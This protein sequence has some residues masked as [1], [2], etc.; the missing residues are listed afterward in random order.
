MKF[1][2]WISYLLVFIL[3]LVFLPVS[4]VNAASDGPRVYKDRGVVNAGFV[5]D[6][7]VVKFKNDHKP[8]RVI[9]V[10]EGKVKEKVQEYALRPDVVYAEPNYYAQAYAAPNDPLYKYQWN[11]ADPA[12]GGIG[13]EAA[14]GQSTGGG[15]IV[16][17]IDTGIAYES[18]GGYVQAPDLAGTAFVPGYDFVNNDNHANDDNSHGTHVAGTVAQSTNNGVGVAGIAYNAKL[19]PIKV[20]DKR[21][22]GSYA[23]IALGI[24]Y[25][26]DNGAKVINM[27]LGGPVPAQVL[28]D[29]LA[30]A[31]GLGVTI[32]AAAGNDATG[33]VGYPAA[34]D[35]YVIAVGATRLDKQL[36]YYSN[37]G[38]SLDLVAPGGD[39]NVD[40]NGDG[41]GDGILQNTFNPS[42]KRVGDFGYYF[43]QGTSM[44]SPHVAGAAALV[45][46]NGIATKPAD[47]QKV[48]QDTA[49]DLGAAGRDDRYGY[50]LVNVAAALGQP[51][52]PPVNQAP[53]ADSQ[54]VSTKVGTPV[55]ITLTASDPDDDVLLFS[56]VNG[57]TSGALSGEAPNLTYTPSVG[58]TG[59]DS[60]SFKAND[61]KLDS[62]IAVVTITVTADSAGTTLE[63]GISMTTQSKK[64]GKNTFVWAVATV[65]TG[66][67][68]AT[69]TGHWEGATTDLD[70]GTTAANG[71]VVLQSD[72]IKWTGE[73]VTFIFVVDQ[74]TK[75]GIIY[76]LTGTTQASVPYPSDGKQP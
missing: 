18:Y 9:K 48:L 43:F 41:Y 23:N 59:T 76:E 13:M 29:A 46:A 16:A 35:A 5:P 58:F 15:V 34:Y 49:V 54:S 17:I 30:Y 73:P 63:I 11:F 27:S 37:W 67:E 56:I 42:T 26:A 1:K 21:G 66:L 60:F 32:V 75:D 7:I 71:T 36:A 2:A 10:P 50:G 6:E 19:M 33:T 25:A 38:T 64:A 68:G 14:W 44:A 53:T 72:Q 61:S 74:M 12:N 8:F 24:R 31:Y 70:S 22:S 47:V 51:V 3:L 4:S 52:E 62:N 55:A 28:E 40:Q 45:I 20:L 57:P 69:V 65:S 39:V